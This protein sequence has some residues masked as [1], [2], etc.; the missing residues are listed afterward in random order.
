MKFPDER[1]DMFAPAFQ[2]AFDNVR[3]NWT[4]I[5]YLFI[6]LF[7]LSGFFK[8]WWKEAVTTFFL[9]VLVLLLQFPEVAQWLVNRVNE[10][11]ATVW[12]WVPLTFGESLEP[13]LGLDPTGPAPRI[14]ATNGGT[15]LAIMLVLLGLSILISRAS[16]PNQIRHRGTQY[17]YVVSPLGAFLGGLLGGLNG[18]LIVNLIREYLTGTNLPTGPSEVAAGLASTNNTLGIASSGVDFRVTDLPS[19]TI[20]T[21]PLA[22]LVVAFGVFVFLAVLSNRVTVSRAGRKLRVPRGYARYKVEKKGDKWSSAAG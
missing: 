3:L 18:F 19:F 5:T 16:L 9:A 15:W 7:V 12:E 22:W 20:L 14:D 11:L 6:G 21:N 13:L 1:F 10:V 8:G 4:L 2:S 17:A